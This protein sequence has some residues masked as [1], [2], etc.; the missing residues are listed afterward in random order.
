MKELF[1]NIGR[2]DLLEVSYVTF[3]ITE[4]EQELDALFETGKYS[5]FSREWVFPEKQI[6]NGSVVDFP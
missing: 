1:L 6:E 2:Q 4:V 5:K 3:A